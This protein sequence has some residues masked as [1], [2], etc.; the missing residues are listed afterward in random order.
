MKAGTCS[1]KNISPIMLQSARLRCLMSVRSMDI[2]PHANQNS[3]F[4]V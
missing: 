2:V 1:V 4:I 3:A